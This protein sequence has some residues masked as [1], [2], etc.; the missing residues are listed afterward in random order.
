MRGLQVQ[1]INDQHDKE[2]LYTTSLYNVLQ[3]GDELPRVRGCCVTHASGSVI[4]GMSR[5]VSV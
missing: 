3:N 4:I 1:G 5:I 2:E